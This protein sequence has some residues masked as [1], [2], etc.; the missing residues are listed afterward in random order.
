[1]WMLQ[2]QRMGPS[3]GKA[4]NLQQNSR[5]MLRRILNAEFNKLKLT[6]YSRRAHL[7][8]D[9]FHDVESGFM[10]NTLP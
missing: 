5:A 6:I 10:C 2:A 1:M 8:S 9:E 3:K 4:Y 7:C